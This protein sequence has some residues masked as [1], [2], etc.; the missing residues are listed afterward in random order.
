MMRSFAG[1]LILVGLIGFV[2]CSIEKDKYEP[3]PEATETLQTL[4]Y[5]AGRLEMGRYVAAVAG[6]VGVLLVLFPKGR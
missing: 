1:L 4:K 3:V 5:P 6:A 2:Y